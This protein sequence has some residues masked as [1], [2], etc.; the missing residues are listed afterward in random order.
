MVLQIKTI[1]ILFFVSFFAKNR[2]KLRDIKFLCKNV[3][4]CWCASVNKLLII[5]KQ[6]RHNMS[7]HVM[8]RVMHFLL[9]GPFY[10]LSRENEEK[11]K[12]K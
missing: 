7:E 10:I 2:I 1:K 8:L 4:R 12:M 6:L 9:K 3:N 5:P 11:L